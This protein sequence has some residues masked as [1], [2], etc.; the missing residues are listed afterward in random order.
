MYK[1]FLKL[2]IIGLFMI[3]CSDTE[4]LISDINQNE[5]TFVN[6]KALT[7]LG[8]KISVDKTQGNV[9]ETF[10]FQ[11]K[12]KN[13][14]WYFGNLDEHLDSLVFKMAETKETIKI[15]EKKPS[16]LALTSKFNHNFYFPGDYN[17]GI[18]G[19]KNGKIIYKEQVGLKVK[20]EKDFLAVNWNNFS[21]SQSLAYSNY[22]QLNTISFSLQFENGHPYVILSNWW[23]NSDNYSDQ[24]HQKNRDYLYNYL[25]KYYSV[26]QYSENNTTDLKNIYLQNFKKT[27][28]NDIPVYIWITAKNKIALMK[29]Y[30]KNTPSQ[31][32]GYRII[33]EPKN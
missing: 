15:F 25:L 11:L 5:T 18:L 28:N 3:S 17:A 2:S 29:E 13:D 16:G 8:L 1:N 33:A 7:D 19:Y 31:F 9:F 22:F 23:E 24:I 14:S 12:Q 26:P 21:E 4:E 6:D 32:L 30:S 20:D 27:I 10:N